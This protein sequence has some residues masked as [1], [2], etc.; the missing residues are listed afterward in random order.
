MANTYSIDL[1]SG[2]SQYLSAADSASLSVT[3]NLTIEAWINIESS[4]SSGKEYDIC[5]KHDN[6]AGNQR[7]WATTYENS[8]G[9]LRFTFRVS[10]DGTS[11][12]Q[13]TAN[14]NYTLTAGQWYHVAFAYSTAGTVICYVNGVSLGSVGSQR[15]SIFNSNT[16]LTIG[17]RDNGG[18]T[19]TAY[20]DGK[21][22]EVRVWAATQS[23]ASIIANKNIELVGNETNLNA[24]W[25]LNNTLDDLTANNNDLTNNG[26]AVFSTNIPFGDSVIAFDNTT[27][28]G[29]SAGTSHTFS[30]VVS[31]GANPYLCVGIM[32]ESASDLVSGVTYNGVTMTQV[33]T[34]SNGSSSRIYLYALGNPSSGTN[35]VVITKSSTTSYPIAWSI[36]GAQ[37]S[38]TV[39]SSAT[40]GFT[41]TT[42]LTTSTTTVAD[43]SWLVMMGRNEGGS[44]WMAAGTG[45]TLRQ[46]NTN[47]SIAMFDSNSAKTPAGSNSLQTTQT[48]SSTGHIIAS[49][50]PFA[51]AGQTRSPSGGVA[52]SGGAMMY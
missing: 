6:G 36:T 3:G 50:A 12:N 20:F 24:Y 28:G 27:S 44:P 51:E 26:T 21:I 42:S 47:N 16:R 32:I 17:A 5:S 11:T 37:S 30:H 29:S 35:D 25:Q 33:A 14:W 1:E 15:T 22:D 18:G 23:Q 49:I 19:A 46:N 4:P 34:L 43:N 45:T 52:Y 7:S 10:S 2:S 8:G 9:T 13:T 40:N 39:D 48:S 38:S 41:T 31:T